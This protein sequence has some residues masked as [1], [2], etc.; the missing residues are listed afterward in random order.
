MLENNIPIQT[1]SFDGPLGLLLA[2]IQKEEVSI[3]EIEINKITQQY[4]EYLVHMQNLNFDLAGDYLYLA[5]T[6]LYLKSKNCIGEEDEE[7][8]LSE[9]GD[10]NLKITTKTELI[11]RLEELQ[12]FQRLGQLIWDLP[13][14]NEVYFTRPK[15]KRKEIADTVLTPLELNSLTEAM[16]DIIKRNNKKLAVVGRERLSLR[17]KLLYLKKL[18][19]MDQK[20]R[21]LE[22]LDGERTVSEV[23]ISFIC[24]LEMARLKK[25]RLTQLEQK[26]EIYI[27]VVQ[28]L[29]DFNVDLADG[30][31]DEDSEDSEEDLP[32]VPLEENS[33]IAR[34]QLIQ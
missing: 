33:Q 9:L 23:V 29:K 2:L 18:L 16:L 24:L 1:E 34:V 27:E 30:F 4:L 11:K 6:L 13:K 21:F 8:L 25:L 12:K 32:Q 28:D 31:E 20:Y 7:D 3:R 15:I 22:I 5:A 10:E 26:K 14:L 17:S 19:K